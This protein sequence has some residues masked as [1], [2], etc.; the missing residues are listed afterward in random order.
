MKGLAEVL[1]LWPVGFTRAYP[2]NAVAA[3]EEIGFIAQDVQPV[4]P[5]AVWQAGMVILADGTGGKESAEPTLALTR[6]HITA[7][8]VNAIKEL[9]VLIAGLRDRIATLEGNGA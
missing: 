3:P 9:N 8:S 6:D 7:I 2:R 1:Q 4:L 5:E